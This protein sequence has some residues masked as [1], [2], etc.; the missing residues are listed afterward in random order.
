DGSVRAAENEAHT[1]GAGHDERSAEEE[2][3]DLHPPEGPRRQ[4]AHE[5]AP[6]AVTG[7]GEPLDQKEGDERQGT[8]DSSLEEPF[9]NAHHARVRGGVRR[10]P[11]GRILNHSHRSTQVL[12]S[13][14]GR[15][16]TPSE[17]KE[18]AHVNP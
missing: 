15:T 12:C 9:H 2:V 4:L 11:A 8:D 14:Y 1:D 10:P 18:P 3:E 5:V 13:V 6:L 7:A 17:L 16:S